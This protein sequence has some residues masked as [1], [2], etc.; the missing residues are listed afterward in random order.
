MILNNFYSSHN[1]IA[2]LVKGDRLY[3]FTSAMRGGK[4]H[5]SRE[6]SPLTKH[7]KIDYLPDVHSA[8]NRWTV[9]KIQR[10]LTSIRTHSV[11][12]TA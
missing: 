12:T 9:G 4:A 2:P 1:D 8:K 6:T 7:R 3:M 10:Q 11:S 5:F